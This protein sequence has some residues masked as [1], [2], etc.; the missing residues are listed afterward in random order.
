M[1]GIGSIG[2]TPSPY[3]NLA[4][5]VHHVSH[6]NQQ[7]GGCQDGHS[8]FPV[9]EA[10]VVGEPT[11]AAH[12]TGPLEL[13]AK[14][15]I[16]LVECPED[17][18]ADIEEDGE[19]AEHKLEEGEG[20]GQPALPFAQVQHDGQGCWDEADG[21]HGHTPLQGRP[22]QVQGGVAE[23]GEDDTGHEG[24]QH[25][26]QAWHGVHVAGDVIEIIAVSHEGHIQGIKHRR[27]AGEC[28]GSDC[29]VPV[30][31]IRQELDVSDGVDDGGQETDESGVAGI[32]DGEVAPEVTKAGPELTYVDYGDDESYNEADAPE[33]HGPVTYGPSPNAHVSHKREGHT[34]GEELQQA[35]EAGA[36]DVN[37]ALVLRCQPGRHSAVMVR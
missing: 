28:S 3:R 12:I 34:G 8:Q 33:G 18:S 2:L 37:G 26:Q 32:G 19:Q 30:R 13:S 23:E 25:L 24:L 27:D 11:D 29:P 17:Q 9:P 16:E 20:P 1:E 31:T 36:H 21:V 5:P 14:L 15:L 4:S 35:E 22:V 6:V 7:V 10:Q